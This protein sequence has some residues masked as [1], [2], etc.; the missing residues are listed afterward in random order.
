MDREWTTGFFKEPVAG[1]LRLGSTNIAGDGQA[2]LLYHG[3]LEKAVNIYPSEH[4][5]RQTIHCQ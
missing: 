1:P 2:D 5:G 4:S 3:G